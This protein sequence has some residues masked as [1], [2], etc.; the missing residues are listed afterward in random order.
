MLRIEA[1]AKKMVFLLKNVYY[2]YYRDNYYLLNRDKEK[3][4]KRITSISNELFMF[5]PRDHSYVSVSGCK[6]S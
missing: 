5:L 1:Q 3:V 6:K 2:Y 4:R